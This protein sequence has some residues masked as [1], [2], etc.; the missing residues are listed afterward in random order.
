MEID[1]DERPP[2]VE[3]QVRGP[4]GQVTKKK[5]VL[6]GEQR[7]GD[8]DKLCNEHVSKQA[9]GLEKLLIEEDTILRLLDADIRLWARFVHS[10]FNFIFYF[11]LCIL[12]SLLI[13]LLLLMGKDI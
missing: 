13:R 9:L 3:L 12:I 6:V 11:L 1:W 4:E 8:D 5:I 2:T 10:A 7:H